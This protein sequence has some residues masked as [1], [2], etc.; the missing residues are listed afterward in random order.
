MFQLSLQH[1]VYYIT[2][3]W[4]LE[5]DDEIDNEPNSEHPEKIIPTLFENK[6]KIELKFKERH[7]FENGLE[8]IMCL[9]KIC[10]LES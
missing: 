8:N 3:V 6:V 1:V 5:K 4:V 9:E 10:F 7:Y 2:F